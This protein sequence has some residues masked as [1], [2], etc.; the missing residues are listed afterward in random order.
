VALVLFLVGL[1][2]ALNMHREYERK[3]NTYLLRTI[4]DHKLPCTP[5]QRG[6][7][8]PEILSGTLN[9]YSNGT[10][11][12]AMTCKNPAGGDMESE[13]KGT[14][15]GNG[16]EFVLKWEGAGETGATVEDNRLVVDIEGVH[17]L[18]E[19]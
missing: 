5:R 6:Q 7:Q 9:L 12:A 3:A 18:Y 19:K 4:D 14:Y 8:N 10:F 1:P 2:V 16:T 17:Y 15:T 11:H 13:F